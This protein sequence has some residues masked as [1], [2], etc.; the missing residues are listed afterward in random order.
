M[1]K[2]IILIPFLLLAGCEGHYRYPCQD[3]ANWDKKECNNEVCKAE[4]SCTSDVLGRNYSPKVE[5]LEENLNTDQTESTE[6]ETPDIH[7]KQ[8]TPKPRKYEDVVEEVNTDTETKQEDLNREVL[9]TQESELTMDTVVETGEH[10]E[11]AK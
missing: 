5:S 10:N 3:P 8:T 1:K 9:D 2:I 4:G 6:V 7:S 11:A